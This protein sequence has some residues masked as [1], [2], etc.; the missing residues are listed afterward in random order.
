MSARRHDVVGELGLAGLAKGQAGGAAVV[1]AELG[2]QAVRRLLLAGELQHQRMHLQLDAFDLLWRDAL[3]R[4]IGRRRR[5]W[6]DDDAAGKGLVAVERISKR[7]PSSW[8]ISASR[9]WWRWSAS[10]RAAPPA[11]LGLAV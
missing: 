3:G 6:V 4:A 11:H 7:W 2:L 1:H 8:L 10:C 9:I 5:C